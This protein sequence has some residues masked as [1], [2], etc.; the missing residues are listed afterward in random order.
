MYVQ[1]FINQNQTCLLCGVSNFD[2]LA[3]SFKKPGDS[4]KKVEIL[5]GQ[6]FCDDKL[7]EHLK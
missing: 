5:A 1:Y 6:F 7:K 4:G 3:R 2:I